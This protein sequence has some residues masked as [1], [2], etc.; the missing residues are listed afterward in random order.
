MDPMA[1]VMVTASPEG[2]EH[3]CPGPPCPLGAGLGPVWCTG[4]EK[5]GDF[6]VFYSGSSQAGWFCPSGGHWVVSGNSFGCQYFCGGGGAADI[7]RE[8]IR[9]H[10]AVLGTGPGKRSP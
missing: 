3:G 2:S 5:I 8:E 4:L 1:F 9:K 7:Q 6:G 10:P